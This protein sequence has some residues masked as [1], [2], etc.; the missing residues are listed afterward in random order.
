[1]SRGYQYYLDI[2]QFM[3]N[4]KDRSIGEEHDL[5]RMI[6]IFIEKQILLKALNNVIEHL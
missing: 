2:Q 6:Q 1:M 4:R 5:I 3:K